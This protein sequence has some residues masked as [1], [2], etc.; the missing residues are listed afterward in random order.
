MRV[1]AAQGSHVGALTPFSLCL[2]SRGADSSVGASLQLM[3]QKRLHR[4]QAVRAEEGD[5]G[6]QLFGAGQLHGAGTDVT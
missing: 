5:H 4:A 1:S 3:H 2:L 6:G